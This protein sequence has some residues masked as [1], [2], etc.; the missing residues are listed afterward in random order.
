MHMRVAKKIKGYLDIIVMTVDF[1]SLFS[2]QSNFLYIF[3]HHDNPPQILASL[4]S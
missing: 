4:E 2:S 3:G 1:L